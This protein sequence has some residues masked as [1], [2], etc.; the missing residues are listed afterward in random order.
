MSRNLTEFPRNVIV[1]LRNNGNT[2]NEIARELLEKYSKTLTK[3]GMQYVWN[4][5]LETGSI[6]DR[7]RTGRP[8]IVSS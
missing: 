1:V 4:K 7:M 6:R 5:Y 3:L 8:N 2:W